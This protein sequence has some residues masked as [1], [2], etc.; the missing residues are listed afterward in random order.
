MFGFDQAPFG[1]GLQRFSFMSSIPRELQSS[2]DSASYGEEP[3]MRCFER[4]GRGD[5]S[6][7]EAI[8][9]ASQAISEP[10]QLAWTLPLALGLWMNTRYADALDALQHPGAEQACGH[11]AYF[12][13]L[14]EARHIKGKHQLACQAYE[15]ALAIEPDRHDTVYNL[16][17]HQG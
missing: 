4:L 15:R 11:M 9:Q 14:D 2:S 7:D 13:L 5:L 10:G 12:T 3:W 17:I 16:P 6:P 1:V 8:Q